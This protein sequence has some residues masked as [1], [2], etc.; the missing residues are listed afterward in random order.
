MGDWD[1]SNDLFSTL[2]AVCTPF[3]LE[4]LAA[5]NLVRDVVWSIADVECI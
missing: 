5:V 2:R 3:T 4:I 1:E